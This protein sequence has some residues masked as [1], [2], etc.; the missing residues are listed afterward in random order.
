MILAGPGWCDEGTGAAILLNFFAFLSGSTKYLRT[1][2]NIKYC[3]IG[4]SSV[5]VLRLHRPTQ[6]QVSPGSGNR[7]RS[8]IR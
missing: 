7:E 5:V 4:V 1:T 3:W 8:R 2:S 6:T